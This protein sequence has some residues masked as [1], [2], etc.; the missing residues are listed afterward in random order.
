MV[1]FSALQPLR[2]LDKA[3]GLPALIER[4]GVLP[5]L[6]KRTARLTMLFAPSN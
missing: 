2:R 6:V 1:H 4:Q 3:P 5:G